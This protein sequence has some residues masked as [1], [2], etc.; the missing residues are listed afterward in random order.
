MESPALLD[1]RKESQGIDSVPGFSSFEAMELAQND[2]TPS[3]LRMI[4]RH[5]WGL[6]EV[7]ANNIPDRDQESEI[8]LPRFKQ[9]SE[10]QN[11]SKNF[12]DSHRAFER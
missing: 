6:P 7:T 12:R 10:L 4:R 2:A 3:S 8:R 9:A 5:P 11:L 1:G